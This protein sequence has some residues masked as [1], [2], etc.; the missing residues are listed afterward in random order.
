LKEEALDRTIW[1]NRFGRG[2][3]HVVRQNTEWMNF[4]RNISHSKKI[5]ERYDTKCILVLTYS[6]RYSCRIL[7]KLEFSWQIFV[8]Y[9]NI[10]FHENPS[11]RSRVVLCGQTDG[12]TW[13]S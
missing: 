2:V 1:R 5:W 3:G 6:A 13:R 8:R 7:M 9:S 4:V 11:S 12:Q 10:K